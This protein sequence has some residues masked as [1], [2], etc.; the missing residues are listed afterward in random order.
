MALPL[1]ASGDFE[2]YLVVLERGIV[3][4]STARVV[5]FFLGFVNLNCW[6]KCPIFV[7]FHFVFKS[8]FCYYLIVEI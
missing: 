5:V 3:V 7:Y 2:T 4:S 1:A 8:S 6:F